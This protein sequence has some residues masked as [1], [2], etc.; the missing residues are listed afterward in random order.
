[1]GSGGDPALVI[2]DAKTGIVFKASEENGGDKYFEV[3][4]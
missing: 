3:K 1:V 2:T 4:D